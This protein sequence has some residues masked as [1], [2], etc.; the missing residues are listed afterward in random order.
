MSQFPRIAQFKDLAAFRSQLTKLSLNL[1]TDDRILSA[2]QGS[3][4]AQSCKVGSFTVGNRWCIHAM[5]GWDGTPDGRP[6]EHTT[7]RWKHFGLSGAKLI[8][9]GEAFA[10]QADG[11]ANPNQLYYRPENQEPMR[12][13]LNALLASHRQRMGSLDHLLV[14]LQLTHSGRFCKPNDKTRFEP[15][16]AYHHPVLDKKFHIKPDDDSVVFTD[17]QI[18]W[19][20]D[21]YIVVAKMAQAIGFQFVDIKACHGYLGHEFLSAYTRPGPYGGDLTGRTRF[22]RE[23]IQGIRAAC[24]GLLIGVRISI[25]DR[26]P[27]HPDPLRGEGDR[28]GPGIPDE[29]HHALPYAGFGCKR[30]NP[31]EID[32]TEPIQLLTMMRDELKVEIVN[33]S[34]GSPYYVPHIQR[35]AFFP[36][37]DGYQP[38]EDPIVGCAR[39][40]NVVRELKKAVSGLPMVG[41]AYTYF[42][43][44]LPHVAQAV[45]RDGWV[46]FVGLGRMVL[47]YPDLPADTLEY[48]ELRKAKLLCRTFSDCTTAPRSGIISGCFPLDDYYKERDENEQ[49]KT[50]KK[51]LRERLK[52]M[53]ES[54]KKTP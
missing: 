31:L 54:V 27:Y 26:P 21:Q 42:Q 48:G 40:V 19:L 18:K 41:T 51:A 8:W 39:Q 7:R 37:S 22:M 4:M 38:P 3:P 17:D 1:P 43:E 47:S 15:R 9:G 35:P 14:G 20:I 24:P 29:F 2:A 30:D 36:P 28:M 52:I 13:L 25:F 23:I 50:A 16:I 53:N 11:R 34:A 10:V 49:L 12:D 32:L 5:E 46:D 44:Y 45:V 33:I 6:S